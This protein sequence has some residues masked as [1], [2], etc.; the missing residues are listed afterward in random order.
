MSIKTSK[1]VLLDM[2]KL[3]PLDGINYRRWSQKLLIF[4]EQ[5]EVDYVLTTDPPYDPPATTL[6]P[7]DP[8]S[9]IGH[10][11]I[12]ARDMSK[13]DKR[14]NGKTSENK[15]KGRPNQKPAP[16]ANLVEQDDDVIATNVEVL[17]K[18]GVLSSPGLNK[19]FD[20]WR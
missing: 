19:D 17:D 6:A 9:F 12:A 11:V 2:P 16:Q 5:L 18:H 8:E 3:E 10:S 20:L 15:R 4:F 13:Q 14:H 1:K 7:S